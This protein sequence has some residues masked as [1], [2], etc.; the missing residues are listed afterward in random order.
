MTAVMFDMVRDVDV[1]GISGA[2][3]IGTVTEYADGDTVLHW[4]TETPSTT[5]YHDI[6]HIEALHGHGGATRL[7]PHETTLERAYKRL[8]PLLITVPARW[9]PV[10]AAPHPDHLD[11]IRLTFST[12]D[13]WDVW[14][15][16]LDGSVDAAV[17]EEI[18]GEIEHRWVSPDGSLWLMWYSPTNDPEVQP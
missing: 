10:T 4:D 16:R 8:V 2:G 11:R 17:H 9:M 3:V 1:T 13:A 14:V 15:R 12:E 18:P 7:V 5:V 6:R